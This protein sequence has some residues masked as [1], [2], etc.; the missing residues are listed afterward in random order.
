MTELTVLQTFRQS[1]RNTDTCTDFLCVCVYDQMLSITQN[2]FLIG[3]HVALVSWYTLCHEHLWFFDSVYIN[4]WY[5]CIMTIHMGAFNP[6]SDDHTTES[7]TFLLELSTSLQ[8]LT[9]M[10]WINIWQKTHCAWLH[11]SCAVK[12]FM[13]Q[14]SIFF[15]FVQKSDYTNIFTTNHHYAGAHKITGTPNSVMQSNTKV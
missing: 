1:F 13:T 14:S 7:S 6:I 10:G 15:Q 12:L 3:S 2:E 11:I 9:S 4:T 5:L 8:I